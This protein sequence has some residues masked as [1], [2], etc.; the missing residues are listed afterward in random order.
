L[1]TKKSP[2]ERDQSCAVAAEPVSF[3]VCETLLTLYLQ[4]HCYS[5][6]TGCVAAEV[7]V[8]CFELLLKEAVKH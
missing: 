4:Q 5:E 1:G 7:P 2:L 3:V 8:I 6:E